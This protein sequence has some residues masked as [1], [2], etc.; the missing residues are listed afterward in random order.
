[1]SNVP[2]KSE[3]EEKGKAHTKYAPSITTQATY[4]LTVVRF[5][6]HPSTTLLPLL[7]LRNVKLASA[8]VLSTAIHGTPFSLH[9]EN[10]SGAFPITAMLYRLLLPA[11]KNPFA[12]L[13]ALVRMIALTT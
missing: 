11:Y 6:N 7:T 1:M 2:R 5:R 12:A 13:Q 8:P 9:R 4:P 3:D 10:T